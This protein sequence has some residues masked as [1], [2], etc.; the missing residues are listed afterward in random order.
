ME[1]YSRTIKLLL[2]SIFTNDVVILIAAV[3]TLFFFLLTIGFR[4][5][6]KKRVNEL[7]RNSNKPFSKYLYFLIN[8][9]YTLFT[10]MITIFP[11]LGMLGTVSGLLGL[12]LANG[13]MD[14]I[15]N[16]FFIALTST[17]WGIVFSVIYK[18]IN[19]L[20]SSGIEEQIENAKQL[21]MSKEQ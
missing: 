9:F 13:D 19:A 7:R 5:S 4:N 12:D 6:I 20:F 17:A 8:T 10:T 14:N 16:N 3:V 11:L 15:K 1:M 18:I 21:S 2:S